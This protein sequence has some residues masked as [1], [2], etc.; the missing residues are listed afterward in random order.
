[1]KYNRTMI[2]SEIRSL[3]R[4]IS[5]RFHGDVIGIFGSYARNEEDES[6]DLDILVKFDEN[7]TLLDL[8]GMGQYLES[9]LSCKVDV[10]SQN[11]MKKEIEPY[12]LED[13]I[14]V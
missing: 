1:M 2:I 5:H 7:A 12:I 13:L 3:K 11:A 4:E 8:I 10:L 6:S 14:A 9:K